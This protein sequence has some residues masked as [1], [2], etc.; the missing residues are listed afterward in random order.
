M[1]IYFF[2]FEMK[3]ETDIKIDL[4]YLLHPIVSDLFSNSFV[5][6]K[7]FLFPNIAL[8]NSNFV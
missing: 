3:R 7:S 6:N 5:L 2:I 4:S 1:Y 8:V